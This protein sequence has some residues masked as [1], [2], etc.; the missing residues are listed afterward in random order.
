[1]QHCMIAPVVLLDVER[2]GLDVVGCGSRVVFRIGAVTAMH[3]IWDQLER[4]IESI[5]I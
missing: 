1:M 3:I 4:D 2:S 5:S